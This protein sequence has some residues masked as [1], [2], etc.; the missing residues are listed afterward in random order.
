MPYMYVRIGKTLTAPQ[1]EILINELGRLIT[2]IP[3]KTGPDLMV[4]LHD[5]DGLSMGGAG[6]PAAYID[7]RVYTKVSLEAKKAFTRALF[8]LLTR[9]FGIET[10]RLYLTIGEYDNWGYDGEFH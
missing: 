1:K 8:A 7:L 9:E 2:L 3:G 10:G 5:G 6:E 4:D